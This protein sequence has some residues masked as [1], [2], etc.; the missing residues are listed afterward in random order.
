MQKLTTQTAG[1]CETR[2]RVRSTSDLD[3]KISLQR[4]PSWQHITP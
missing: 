2:E 1:M 3:L 4:H